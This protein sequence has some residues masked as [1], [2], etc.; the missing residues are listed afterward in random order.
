M[1]KPPDYSALINP[2][3]CNAF[4]MRYEGRQDLIHS[5]VLD[6]GCS[7]G[8]RLINEIFDGTTQSRVCDAL[9][10]ISP[11]VTLT[12]P[13]R[14]DWA[15]EFFLARLTVK[16]DGET[17]VAD[18][19]VEKFL[20]AP[21]CQI[22]VSE[23]GFG[24]PVVI[25]GRQEEALLG[26]CRLNFLPN[27]SRLEGVLREIP[28]GAGNIR[29]NAGVILAR[30][31]TKPKTG[32][33]FE[34]GHLDQAQQV[35]PIS[36]EWPHDDKEHVTLTKEQLEVPALRQILQEKDA[37]LTEQASKI[38]NLSETLAHAKSKAPAP[39]AELARN[40]LAEIQKRLQRPPEE[41]KPVKLR[42]AAESSFEETF[43]RAKRHLVAWG[44]MGTVILIAMLLLFL[45]IH[46]R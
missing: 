9:M 40:K 23:R 11:F 39:D 12:T 28:S 22:A 27:G 5:L 25:L 46:R 19:F 21:P 16:A 41:S 20:V 7:R 45:G 2:I 10:F 3:A 38:Q 33:L 24:D 42:L 4:P 18:E 31:S 1:I 35:Y 29:L 34:V 8:G 13:V 15:G 26:G 14:P 32:C 37:L 6:T 17:V 30:Y 43:A 36:H 44:I